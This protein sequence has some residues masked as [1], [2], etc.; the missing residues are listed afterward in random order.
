MSKRTHLE[1]IK[2]VPDFIAKLGLSK[3]KE[4]LARQQEPKLED[5]F[6]KKSV[7]K[8]EEEKGEYDF[9]NAQI[10]DLANMLNGGPLKDE[11]SIQD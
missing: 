7:G 11:E 9:E 2:H 4:T 1:Y 8:D 3:E 5:K 6:E 10:E